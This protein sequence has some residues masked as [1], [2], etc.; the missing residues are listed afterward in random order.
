M[1]DQRKTIEQLEQDVWGEPNADSTGLVRT[2]YALRKKPLQDFTPRDMQLMIGQ[3]NNFG[4]LIPKALHV[5]KA[6][7]LIESD[8]FYPGHLL[9]TVLRLHNTARFWDINPVLAQTAVAV[10][11]H[12]L[13]ILMSLNAGEG[14]FWSSKEAKIVQEEDF[15]ITDQI[16]QA[17]TATIHRFLDQYGDK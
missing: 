5:L 10:A 12:A 4:L 13:D 6:N 7:P 14:Y 15:I 16:Y 17:L 9:E 1:P 8:T 11:Q 2:C 3:S